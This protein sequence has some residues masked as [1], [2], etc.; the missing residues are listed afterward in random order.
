A[1]RGGGAGSNTVQPIFC[2]SRDSGLRGLVLAT[3][4]RTGTRYVLPFDS[5][6]S[7]FGFLR[8]TP[9]TPAFQEDYAV[10]PGPGGGLKRDR[11]VEFVRS[12]GGRG[13]RGPG[14]GRRPWTVLSAGCQLFEELSERA[15]QL[16]NDL[17]FRRLGAGA[18]TRSLD[19]PTLAL[20]IG[21]V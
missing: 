4:W 5:L 2:S 3:I 17:A 13:L 7:M 15:G 9:A 19:R 12:F 21:L 14:S 11:V 8:N 6:R 18:G 1:G 10:S 20:I 16:A